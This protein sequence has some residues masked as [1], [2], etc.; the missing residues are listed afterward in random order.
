MIKI[1]VETALSTFSYT[2]EED[3]KTP[4]E[5]QVKAIAAALSKEHPGYV[6]IYKN[7]HRESCWHLYQD[8]LTLKEIS[9]ITGLTYHTLR[10]RT[11]NPTLYKKLPVVQQPG[12]DRIF[13]KFKDFENYDFSKDA[14]IKAKKAQRYREKLDGKDEILRVY[15]EDGLAMKSIA[16]AMNVSLNTLKTYMQKHHPDVWENRKKR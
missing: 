7:P 2:F 10:T 16:K 12:S 11:T 3:G 4:V 15:F 14:T 1:I 5:E 9:N 8:L 6:N 13:V